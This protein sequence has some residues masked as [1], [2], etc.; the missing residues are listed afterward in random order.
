MTEEQ[1][2]AMS[3]WARKG[4]L[5][6]GLREADEARRSGKLEGPKPTDDVELKYYLDTFGKSGMMAAT[7]CASSDCACTGV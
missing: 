6:K 7:N 4:V 1:V 2:E 5:E 3:A